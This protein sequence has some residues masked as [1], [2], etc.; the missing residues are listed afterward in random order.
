M[1]HITSSKRQCCLATQFHPNKSFVLLVDVQWKENGEET[2]YGV[3]GDP[4]VALG[5]I[6]QNPV[7][8]SP[9]QAIKLKSGIML[10][11]R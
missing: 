8:S 4:P 5:E 7:S 11:Q 10:L 2:P 9:R 3:A 6:R 1:P